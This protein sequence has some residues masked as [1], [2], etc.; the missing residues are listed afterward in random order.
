MYLV[1]SYIDK[2]VVINYA[3]STGG[4][5]M[6]LS[7]RLNT[8]QRLLISATITSLPSHVITHK[9]ISCVF[10]SKQIAGDVCRST[11]FISE[12]FE[13]IFINFRV[14]GHR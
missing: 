11:C 10:C 7:S 3:D 14:R 5:N 1:S 2:S 12:R 6:K 4:R 9:A 8:I 13:G